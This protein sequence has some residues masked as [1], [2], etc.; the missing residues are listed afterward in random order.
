M[1]GRPASP[2]DSSILPSSTSTKRA[3]SPDGRQFYAMKMVT[4]RPLDRV[5][6][7]TPAFDERLALL[8]RVVPVFEAV[9][10]AHHKGVIHRD[11]KP[12]NV[13]IGEFGETV[14][15]DWGLAKELGDD[16][17][18]ATAVARPDPSGRSEAQGTGADVAQ[19]SRESNLTMA[20]SVMGTPAYMPPEQ[21]RGEEIGKTADVY[22]LG[23]MLY[24]LLAGRP[25][26]SARSADTLIRKLLEGPPPPLDQTEAGIPADLLSI[27]NKSMARNPSERYRD[28]GGLMEEVSRFEAGQLVASHHY[29]PAEMAAR[30][31]KRHRAPVA[32][33][34]ISLL[35]MVVGATISV[36]RILERE[37]AAR[38]AQAVAEARSDE[39]RLEQA[40]SSLDTDPLQAVA[41]LKEIEDLTPLLAESRLVAADAVSRGL[42]QTLWEGQSWVNATAVR[43]ERI[44]LGTEDGVVAIVHPDGSGTL[45]LGSH[46]GPVSRVIL[47]RRGQMLSSGL[48]GKIRFWGPNPKVLSG[49]PGPI[50]DM[51]L[52]ADERW[53][54]TGGDDGIARLW[55]LSTGG[56]IDL[57]GHEA[58]IVDVAF[59]SDGRWL[60]TASHDRTARIW[61]VAGPRRSVL[62]GHTQE[63]TGVTFSPDGGCITTASE[64][65]SIRWWEVLGE[66]RGIFRG[67]EKATMQARFLSP[68]SILS[69]SDD[70]TSRIWDMRGASLRVHRGHTSYISDL[71]VSAD[72]RW[73]A[74][75]SYDNSVGIWSLSSGQGRFLRGH[76]GVVT[77]VNFSADGRSIYSSSRDGTIRAW[78]I[79]DPAGT[80]IHQEGDLWRSEISPDGSVV[81]VS[82]SG[83]G[84]INRKEILRYESPN[85]LVYASAGEGGMLLVEGSGRVL[86]WDRQ[87]T[88]IGDFG[89]PV[90]PAAHASRQVAGAFDDGE[91][92]VIELDTGTTRTVTGPGPRVVALTYGPSGSLAWADRSGNI[93]VVDSQ[94]KTLL[95]AS[96]RGAP[97]EGLRLSPDGSRLVCLRAKDVNAYLWQLSSGDLR[98]LR[99]HDNWVLDAQFS[100]DGR[101]LATG[102]FDTTIRI[103]SLDDSEPPRVLS[104]H[105]GWVRSVSFSSDGRQ[106]ASGSVDQTVRWW[107]LST[108]RSRALRGHQHEL[109][110][111]FF[112]P[113]DTVLSIDGDGS[114]WHWKDEVPSSPDEFRDW[115]DE[116]FLSGGH[117]THHRKR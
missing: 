47:S 56:R 72:E 69:G 9:A 54:A 73:L 7:E 80:R 57:P 93:R 86:R 53:L 104:G 2:L 42:P 97:P 98:V 49:H 83:A 11:L 16:V 40:R 32:I 31:L 76:R 3:V 77:S 117:R 20:G 109:K 112:L 114:I 37:E 6:E 94:G 43:D 91:I 24:H 63:V 52:S 28:A 12:A 113:D 13:I 14:V 105:D 15:I 19:G 27:V 25:P 62:R 82:G 95:Q 78:P 68:G 85:P 8:R 116:K 30:F 48:D 100:S 74:S 96:L 21:A 51:A 39:L 61:E 10:F 60:A 75:A 88:T 106:L 23:A 66:D 4:G 108:G 89:R 50:R 101:W 34:T 70:G 103:W 79:G 45:E 26:Y 110:K 64:D 44:L 41:W 111:V 67:H 22:A 1:S 81:I 5:I 102:G 35:L 99:G 18:T 55:E 29:T 84:R 36:R 38:R 115:I 92:V 65:R 46:D 59:S 33:A 90:Y 58:P 71:A 87:A 17:P 107:D